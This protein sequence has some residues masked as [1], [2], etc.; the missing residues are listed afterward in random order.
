VKVFIFLSAVP[1]SAVVSDAMGVE[2][3]FLGLT[4]S[5]EELCSW[6][7]LNGTSTVHGFGS[8]SVLSREFNCKKLIGL[9]PLRNQVLVRSLYIFDMH[10]CGA[11][12]TCTTVAGSTE[13]ALY[14]QSGKSGW[15]V[16]DTSLPG[17]TRGKVI[18]AFYS[19]K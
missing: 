10:R 7:L 6:A 2:L 12:L 8:S 19:V 5:T 13:L 3:F 16:L 15:C 14:C 1:L 17:S 4:V 18:S 9:L 11:F